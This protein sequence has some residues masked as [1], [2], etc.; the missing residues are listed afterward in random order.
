MGE[1]RCYR[2]GFLLVNANLL[3]DFFSAILAPLSSVTVLRTGGL[4]ASS[5]PSS[6]SIGDI[7]D[8][9]C[10]ALD[11]SAVSDFLL[12]IE[13][14]EDSLMTLF[15]IDLVSSTSTF[16]SLSISGGTK[17]TTSPCSKDFARSAA[18]SLL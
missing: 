4:I 12:C 1:G 10:L 13:P 5:I 17:S 3:I 16:S 8:M 18:L 2:A 7:S 6:S 9:R 15:A 11:T 14:M